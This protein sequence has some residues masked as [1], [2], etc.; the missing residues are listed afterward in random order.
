MM[1]WAIVATI[2]IGLIAD[3]KA[4]P[5]GQ[6]CVSV[7]AWLLFGALWLR[8]SREQRA[9]LV[10]CLVYATA[11]EMFLS[12]ACGLYEYRLHNIPF[13]VPP[14][15]VLLFAL[16][17]SVASRLPDSAV[18]IVVAWAVPAIAYLAF[19]GTDTLGPFLLGLLLVCLIFG[20]SKKLY[21]TMFVLALLMELYGTW[22]GNWEWSNE[23][24][25]LRLRTANPPVAAGAFY[26][27]L[28]LL[29]LA[30]VAGLRR[31]ATRT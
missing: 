24:A 1:N 30:T 14:G 8:S 11:G 2:T 22:L 29:V 5:Y 20:P 10:A 9:G 4:G 18:W 12:L 19:T 17:A 15:H 21:A 13:F 23:L 6:L 31:A 25:W 26:C 3:Q 27:V 16:G 7:A 28:D